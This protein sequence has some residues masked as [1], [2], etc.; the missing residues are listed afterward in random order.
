[1]KAKLPWFL[2]AVPSAGCAKGGIGAFSDALERDP[3]DLSG[4][5]GLHQGVVA[6][7]SFRTQYVPLSKQQDFIDALQVSIPVAAS[8]GRACRPAHDQAS[9]VPDSPQIALPC[10]F[11]PQGPRR[12]ELPSGAAALQPF[13]NPFI[14]ADIHNS[15]HYCQRWNF[16][17]LPLRG[18]FP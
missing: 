13:S 10:C 8:S 16:N 17:L 2:E 4:V 12:H 6:A 7:S 15:L 5:A 18:A 14:P 11:R 1:M 9:R 3:Q